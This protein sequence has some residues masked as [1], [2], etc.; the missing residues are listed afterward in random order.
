M[1]E[2]NIIAA[3]SYAN[4]KYFFDAESCAEIPGGVRKELE[5]LC[6]SAAE[7]I[8]GVF[9]VAYMQKSGEIIFAADSDDDNEIDFDE[10]GARLITDKFVKENSEL[11][12]S[13]QLWHALYKTEQG[14]KII[15]KLKKNIRN[16]GE[17]Q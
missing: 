10:I 1:E 14:Q 3:A 7:L 15:E 9:S 13:L 2:K 5:T 12:K 6:K 17:K 8:Q 4:K 16:T 11:I